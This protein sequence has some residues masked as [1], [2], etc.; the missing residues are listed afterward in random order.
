MKNRVLFLLIAT[1]CA[2]L[3][4]CMNL[5]AQD[6]W[7]DRTPV[8][9]WFSKSEPVDIARLGKQYRITDYGVANDSTILQ[10]VQ[11]QAVIDK[12]AE[13]GGGVIIVP[14]G[15]FL[16][17]SLFFKQG[18]HLRLEEKAVLK[19]SDDISDFALLMTRIEGQTVKYFAALINA[20]G[21]DGFTLSGK[22]T[23]NGN[24]VRYWKA[25]WL[26][27]QWN[28]QC[29]NKDEQRPRLLFVS[30]SKN[31][32]ISGVRLINSPFWT[33][34]YY[35]CENLKILGVYFYAPTSGVK[36]PS[37][38]GMDIDVCQ[39]VLIKGCFTSVN[40]DG[41]ALKGGKGPTAD[42]DPTNGTNRNI[43]IE[44]NTFNNCPSLTIGSESVHTYNVI[45]RRC[46]V[47][48]TSNVLQL[49]MRPDTP[50]RH[51]FILVEN[52][53]GT[54]RAFFSINPW[55]QFFDLQGQPAPKSSVS[56]ITIRNC[57]VEAGRFFNVRTSEQYT[58]SDFTFENLNIKA[59]SGAN[60]DTTLIE[61]FA[62]KNV[63]VN[64]VKISK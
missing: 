54:A 51:E 25:F 58:L 52:I 23:I 14:Q 13:N 44:D 62:L 53:T 28:P 27:R 59:T 24:G 41:I 19:G 43:L 45:M 34:H 18:T 8:S 47:I 29:T 61:N 39:N 38:D 60:I 33:S 42:K 22:G 36:A 57:D 10:T 15:T 12:A 1:F 11:I 40:D 55:T 5:N 7:P 21:L 37:S 9:A 32:E 49:K 17:G 46:K 16:T 31:V 48:N 30:N 64:G 56:N 4:P 2:V 26:R 3:I 63:V 6:V 35:Q 20:D 50:Q